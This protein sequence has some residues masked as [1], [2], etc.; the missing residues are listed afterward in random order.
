MESFLHVES[1]AQDFRG[2]YP[3]K[4]YAHGNYGKASNSELHLRA[5]LN[6]WHLTSG[7]GVPSPKC[8]MMPR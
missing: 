2:K 4:E 7:T 1:A 6:P 3:A 8:S 5:R